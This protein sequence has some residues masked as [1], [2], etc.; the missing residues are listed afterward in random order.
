MIRKA[1]SQAMLGP[2][3]PGN[4]LRLA[5]GFAPAVVFELLVGRAIPARANQIALLPLAIASRQL[6]SVCACVPDASMVAQPM[7]PIL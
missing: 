5:A 7:W 1:V 4:V 2:R 3:R 6:R